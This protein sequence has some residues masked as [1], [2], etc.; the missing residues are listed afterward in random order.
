[1]KNTFWATC[2]TAFS[3][4]QGEVRMLTKV[5]LW[6]RG[7]NFEE[8]EDFPSQREAKKFI[9]EYLAFNSESH[10]RQYREYCCSIILLTFKILSSAIDSPISVR[11]L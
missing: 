2:D 8:F 1:M 11:T 9:L 10:P 5:D 6:Y 7:E 4:I 3:F